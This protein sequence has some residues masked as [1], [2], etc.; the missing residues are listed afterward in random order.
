MATMLGK[1]FSLE[2]FIYSDTAKAKN[3]NNSPG[4]EHYLNMIEFVRNVLD[5]LREDWGQYCIENNLDSPGLRISSGYRGPTLNKEVGGSSTSQHC[6]GQAADIIPTNGKLLEF[7][8][9]CFKW[10]YEK[11]NVAGKKF[12]NQIISEGQVGSSIEGKPR[13][14]HIASGGENRGEFMYAATKNGKANGSVGGAVK[15]SIKDVERFI[16]NTTI[17][18]MS[19]PSTDGPIPDY[20]APEYEN[21]IKSY[22]ETYDRFYEVSET[23]DSTSSDSNNI[24]RIDPSN[25]QNWFETKY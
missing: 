23:I 15:Y 10:V 7:K 18:Y 11:H 19:E 16:N 22:N 2:E 3:I 13:W 20:E 21:F 24:L 14:I 12:F 4:N 17:N 5:P 25:N 1:Y 6:H 9:F 8:K